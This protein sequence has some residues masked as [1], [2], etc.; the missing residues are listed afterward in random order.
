MTSG[1]AMR[2]T[3]SV[4]VPPVL[5]WF[6]V[7]SAAPQFRQFAVEA[8]IVWFALS[9]VRAAIV[10]GGTVRIA[11]DVPSMYDDFERETV[12]TPVPIAQAV[13]A[14]RLAA[15]VDDA[16]VVERDLLPMLRALS[17]LPIPAAPVGRAA[18][19]ALLDRIEAGQ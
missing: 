18:L 9:L 17:A 10:A 12:A 7:M 11:G 15:L 4:F 1:A 3:A 6:A 8:I 13:R 19:G 5:G 14:D 2:A 16:E